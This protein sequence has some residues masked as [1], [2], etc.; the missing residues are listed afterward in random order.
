MKR[1]LILVFLAL[2][3]TAP[4]EATAAA[5]QARLLP[6]LPP[7]RLMTQVGA[8]VPPSRKFVSGFVI[9]AERGYEVGVQ[10]FGSA[11]ILVVSHG[12]PQNQMSETVYLAR[13]VA[14]PER[15]QATF[16]KFGKVSMRF[17][18]SHHRPWFGQRR[19]CRGADRFVKRRGVF[20]GN[21]RFRGEDG[22]VSVHVH[23]AKGAIVT[24]AAKCSPHRRAKRA[25]SSSIF[26]FEPPSVL[27]ATARDGV[28]TTAFLA[29]QF[30]GR[31]AS[32]MAVEEEDRGKLAIIR[33]AMVLRR[34]HLEVNDALTSANA[35]P[36]APFHGTGRYSAAPDGSTAWSGSLSVNFPGAPR[37]PITG[38]QFETFLEVPF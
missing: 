1:A 31:K 13:G 4:T 12:Q 28:D 8:P 30:K 32:Y 25:Q 10:T 33:L 29:L 14:T 26:D 16:G 37:F 34:G 9:D 24:K 35:S 36:G 22:Y 27:L 18:E 2:V 7:K 38:P 19:R 3:L 6:A 15:L 17:R 20:V 11:V 21:L 23:R 5:R